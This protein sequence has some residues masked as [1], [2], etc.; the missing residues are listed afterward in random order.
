MSV[1]IELTRGHHNHVY[2]KML[3]ISGGLSSLLLSLTEKKN[4]ALQLLKNGNYLR[5]KSMMVSMHFWS[6]FVFLNTGEQNFDRKW[7]ARI[8]LRFFLF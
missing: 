2:F 8:E 6:N 7:F 1:T 3:F 5:V 4:A